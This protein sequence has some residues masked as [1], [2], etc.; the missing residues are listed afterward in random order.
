MDETIDNE[1]VIIPI[2]PPENATGNI[3]DEDSGDEDGGG[4]INN[5]PGSMLSAP[6]VFEEDE[7]TENDLEP[8]FKKI[9]TPTERKWVKRDIS[10]KLSKFASDDMK[11]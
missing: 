6:A 5:L 7:D 9:R 4:T 3:T 8:K 2:L 10:E 11:Y 1:P